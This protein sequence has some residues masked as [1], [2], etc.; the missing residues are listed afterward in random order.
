MS[1]SSYWQLHAL[2][3]CS[4]RLLDAIAGLDDAGCGGMLRQTSLHR[5]D[6]SAAS[7]EL[8]RPGCVWAEPLPSLL[9]QR[10]RQRPRRSNRA[11][12]RLPD[13]FSWGLLMRANNHYLLGWLRRRSARSRQLQI[14]HADEP[15][16]IRAATSFSIPHNLCGPNQCRWERYILLKIPRSLRSTYAPIGPS[17]FWP[18]PHPSRPSLAMHAALRRANKQQQNK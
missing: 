9:V 17:E 10:S 1:P 3:N 14:F 8:L 18:R 11:S 15:A 2:A 7:C 16:F 4:C 12:Q 13:V 5:P 6:G